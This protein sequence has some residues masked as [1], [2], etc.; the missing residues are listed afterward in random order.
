MK[1]DFSQ[2]FKESSYSSIHVLAEDER[3]GRFVVLC[4]IY[5]DEDAIYELPFLELPRNQDLTMH[6]LKFLYD[7]NL[8]LES[9]RILE[10]ETIALFSFVD[11]TPGEKI[12][13]IC[14]HAMVYKIDLP[15]VNAQQLKLVSLPELCDLADIIHGNRTVRH[16]L[17][18]VC[19]ERSY[20][21]N[22][23]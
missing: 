4:S 19:T 13:H 2:P 17:A 16:G 22:F 21:I 12:E 5:D 15:E 7:Y 6:L 9:F 3:S 23:M 14:V 11:D 8:V 20:P 10:R 1:Q 18:K